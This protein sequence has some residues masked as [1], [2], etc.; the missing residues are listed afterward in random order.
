M[1]NVSDF[2]EN[3]GKTDTKAF[4]ILKNTWQETVPKL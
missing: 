2:D 4:K 1:E 3:F